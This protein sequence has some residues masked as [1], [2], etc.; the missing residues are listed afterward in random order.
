MEVKFVKMSPTQ[1]MTI[2]VESLLP[3]ESY[4][5]VA[6][7]L[8]KYENIHAEQVGFIEP[9]ERP[10][11]W[12]RLWMMGGEFC[13]NASMALAAFLAWERNLPAGQPLNVPLEVSGLQD[14][15]T[16]S[17]TRQEY[18]SRCSIQMPPPEKIEFLT[19]SLKDQVYQAAVIHLEGITHIIIDAAQVSG[20]KERF[21]EMAIREWAKHFNP[22]AL[23]VVIFDRVR[24]YIKP[25]VYVPSAGS[26]TWERGCGSGTAAIGAFLAHSASGTIGADITQPGG[27]ISVKAGYDQ[28]RMM[29]TAITG[30]V[31]LVARG[32]AYL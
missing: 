12:A 9:A 24:N 14:L 16:V 18:E 29:K 23:G 2:L 28:E 32:V 3:R 17:L 11:A 13:G 5:Q 31:R 1:N 10:E 15:I 22:E 4:Q 26:L 25:L 27:V 6:R 19:L 7:E 20:D 21:A 8:M 30:Q